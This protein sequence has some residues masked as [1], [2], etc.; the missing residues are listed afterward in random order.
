MIIDNLVG[1]PGKMTKPS[2]PPTARFGS[3]MMK[4]CFSKLKL[5]SGMFPKMLGTMWLDAV[6]HW[7]EF[8]E[9]YVPAS[10]CLTLRMDEFVSK[11]DNAKR[12]SV[13]REVLFSEIPTDEATV[14]KG[15]GVF[16]VHSQ[17]GS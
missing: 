12:E 9:K 5:P 15:M 1:G 2:G 16:A 4:E 17:A 7:M 6:A 11:G 14:A 3:T 10:S 13:V 8:K